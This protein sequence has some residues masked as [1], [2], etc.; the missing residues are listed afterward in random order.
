M[1]L[2]VTD[3]E[4]TDMDQTV[5]AIVHAASLPMSIIIVGVGSADFTNMELLDADKRK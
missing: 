4:I 5:H 2:I 1:L 3:G